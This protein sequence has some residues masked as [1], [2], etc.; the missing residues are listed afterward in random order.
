MKTLDLIEELIQSTKAHQLNNLEMANVT[1]VRSWIQEHA[2]FRLKLARQSGIS[3]AISD[4][5]KNNN[6]TIVICHHQQLR[7]L[8]RGS[9]FSIGGRPD[10][11]GSGLSTSYDVVLFDLNGL[12][13]VHAYEYAS[14]MIPPAFS[15]KTTFGI[16]G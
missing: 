10:T 3:S 4:Y 16:L 5:V 11:L 9:A 12:S 13:E 8:P 7:H 1:S 15:L 6:N 14:K 2:S